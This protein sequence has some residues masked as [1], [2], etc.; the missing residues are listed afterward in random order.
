MHP[1]L[2]PNVRRLL[3]A[4]AAR[5]VGQGA[6]VASFSLY[7][8]AL[9]FSGAA[10][11]TVLMAGLLFGALLTLIIGPLSDKVSRRAL[12]LGYEI[13]AALAA[14][15]A[16]LAPSL[17][18]L[19]VAATVAGF[20]RGANGAA[21]PFSPV[22]QA[23]L[24]REVAGEARRRAFSI[25]ATLGFLGMAAGAALIALPAALGVGFHSLA[26]YRALFGLPL[27][28]SVVSFILVAQARVT[29][30]APPPPPV[31]QP[32]RETHVTRAEN[33]LL[34]RLA[35]VSAINGFAIGIVNP[36]IA[37]WFLRRFSEGPAVIGPA[38]A[39]SFVL[40]SAG[41]VFGGR[42]SLRLGA[43]R[44]VV[45][46]R[47]VGLGLLVAIPFSPTF[48]LAAG[49]YA[50]RSAFNRGTTGARQAVAAGLTRAERR[51]L[52]ASVQSLSA[53]LPRA[54][55]PVLGG[56]LI[57]RGEF[58][59]PFLL[60]AVMQALYLFLYRQFFRDVGTEAT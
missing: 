20:G 50:L 27:A 39:V 49:L 55:G 33:R 8:Q 37:Y 40:A 38:L 9:G 14:L 47:L 29:T 22:E 42:L 13:V 26:S 52:A 28:G 54:A 12:L 5:S 43:V 56:W 2:P 45:W 32:A 31:D 23:W 11:G 58:V 35:A 41:S 3:A 24:A 19:L 4:R 18:V 16:M 10:I 53:Q 57:H 15:A 34:R 30:A 25:N 59:A 17:T 60:T 48:L 36:L 6:T 51:G 1:A 44:S 21:G 7:L 46:M